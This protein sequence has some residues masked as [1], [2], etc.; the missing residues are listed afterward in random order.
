MDASRYM[1]LGF[2]L[3]L[4]PNY[5]VFPTAVVYIF[6]L[7]FLTKWTIL[8]FFLLVISIFVCWCYRAYPT[9][10]AS[11]QTTTSSRTAK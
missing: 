7:F 5:F 6:L 9:A 3:F 11:S 10:S 1:M 2:S 8:K 4:T